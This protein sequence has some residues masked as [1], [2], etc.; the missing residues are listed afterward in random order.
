MGRDGVVFEGEIDLAAHLEVEGAVAAL[1]S[2]ERVVTIDLSGV[3]FIDGAGL[4]A[5]V[6]LAEAAIAT[7]ATVRYGRSLSVDRYL[8][9]VDRALPVGSTPWS[10][11]TTR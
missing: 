8:D 2:G 5:L 7:G 10:E 3:T 4:N 11:M 9:L 1:G 6:H